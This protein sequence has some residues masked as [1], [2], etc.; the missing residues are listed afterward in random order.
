MQAV[1]VHRGQGGFA[2]ILALLALMLLT[3]LGLTL[4]TTTSLE[5]QIA[6]NYRWSQQ[7]LYNAEAG[8]EVGRS[9]IANIGDITQIVP[10]PRTFMWDENALP[11]P[12]PDPPPGRPNWGRWRT[13][14]A[15]QVARNFENDTCDRRG[16]GAGYGVVLDD[17]VAAGA[18]FQNVT[19]VFG[20]NLNGTFTLWARRRV[21]FDAAGQLTDVPGD[22]SLILTSEG[23]APFGS[24]MQATNYAANNR[25]VRVLE[26]EVWLTAGCFNSAA[27]GNQNNFSGCNPLPPPGGP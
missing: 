1:Q 3:F 16:N 5:L 18:P 19:T 27:Q 26:A 25:A 21:D 13:D 4:A 20:E 2:L 9:L 17:G 11:N 22:D 10:A 8:L 24:A 14:A 23:T 6:A 12:L 7:A 15:G